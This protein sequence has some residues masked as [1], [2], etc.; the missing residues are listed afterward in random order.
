[1]FSVPLRLLALIPLAVGI[2]TAMGIFASSLPIPVFL[3]T[4]GTVLVAALAGPWVALATGL[5]SQLVKGVFVS[6]IQLA[7][8]PI[9]LLVA[10]YAAVACS[11]FA[12]FASI[13]RAVGGGLLLG[14]VAAT[15]SWP[16][17][18][19][20]FGGVT[21]P[22]VATVTTIMRGLGLPLEWA[23]YVASLSSDLIDKTATFLL[24]RAILVSLPVRMTARF[25]AALAALGRT[26]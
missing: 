23:V 7:F 1:M 18:Y 2:N 17:S 20:A 21:S 6:G 11:R 14:I 13:P 25:P 5:V 10:V 15:L 3:D 4:V 12:V 26:G 22:G 19:L 24:V 16:I 9:Q 8:L